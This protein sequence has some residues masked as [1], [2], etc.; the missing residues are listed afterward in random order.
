MYSRNEKIQRVR[1]LALCIL[2]FYTLDLEYCL[3]S[4]KISTKLVEIKGLHWRNI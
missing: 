3:R 4:L 1:V 2:S